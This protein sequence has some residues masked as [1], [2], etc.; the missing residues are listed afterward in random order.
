MARRRRGKWILIGVLLLVGIAVALSRGS[1]PTV[2]EGS[3]VVVRI[4]GSYAEGQ[5]KNQITKLFDE[6][7]VLV[8][9][10]DTLRKVRADPRI[11]GVVARIGPL[12]TGW[13]QTRE[14]RDALAALRAADKRVVSFMSSEIIG[15]NKEYYLASVG[16]EVLLASA[17]APMLNGL[18]AHYYFL[19]ALWEKLHIA[20]E[21]E[22]IREYKTFGDLLKRRSMSPAHR[23]MADSVLDDIND[24]FLST[25][26]EARGLTVEET[27]EI[28]NSCPSSAGDFV[29]AG[30][31]DDVLFFD[32]LSTRIDTDRVV[33]FIDAEEYAAV[34]LASVGLGGGAR[35]AVIHAVGTIVPGK[36]GRR[37]LMGS[38][39]GSRP[40]VKAFR[41]A[42]D[43]DSI[44]AIVF[45]ID[46]PG[47]SAMASDDVWRAT[48]LAREKKPVVT[49]F[50]NVA[51]SGGYYMAAGTDHIV[52]E[53]T[54]L[55]GSIGVVLF[56]PNV[57]GLLGWMGIGTESLGRGR[58]SRIMDTSKGLDRAEA[59]LLRGQMDGVYKRF[60]D[61]VAEGRAMTVEEVDRVGGG[62]VWTGHQ[63]LEEG[64]IDELGG[65]EQAVRAAAVEAQVEDP[66]SVEL[67]YLPELKGLLDQLMHLQSSRMS[68]NV[69]AVLSDA[70]ESLAPYAGLETGIHVITD[71]IPAIR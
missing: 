12:E 30:L 50:G 26:A 69:P 17:A 10:L 54:T 59:S 15:G 8:E 70:I 32:E 2:A 49:S 71:A 44:S 57:A 63:A 56:K 1:E 67:V 39:V 13:A 28:V 58:Y 29:E 38:T 51:A 46:S 42:A 6:R 4:E 21:V 43:D 61:R 25:I 53:P 48:R 14:I 31:A 11:P 68:A 45:R 27:Q 33:E 37:G 60:L 16:D 9:L 41:T 47:G 35:I 18:S 34:S 24:E 40:L 52:A 20:M 64:L 66:S 23:E 22:Q 19:G 7:K 5:P 3:Y 65:L 55:T 36:G 62:R